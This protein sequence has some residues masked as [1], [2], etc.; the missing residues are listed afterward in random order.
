MASGAPSTAAIPYNPNG[1]TTP[2]AICT[3]IGRINT[4]NPGP[5][6]AHLLIGSYKGYSGVKGKQ[7][8]YLDTFK[9]LIRSGHAI[10]F[11]GLVPKQYSVEQPALNEGAFDAPQGFITASGHGQ[12]IVGFDD[13]IGPGGAFLIQNS[14]GPAW[15]PGPADDP[16]FNGR[17]WCSYRSWFSGQSLA[18]IMYPNNDQPP[19]GAKLVA[20]TKTAPDLY[21]KESRRY[22]QDGNSYLALIVHGT[23]AVTISQ[24]VVTGPKGLAAT[25]ALNEMMRFGY[26]YV[27]RKPAY[28]PGHNTAS[29]SVKTQAGK[30]VTYKGGFDVT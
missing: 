21:L 14:F 19:A 4:S 23:E 22:Q 2:A 20:S 27:E 3:E 12:V 18:L 28:D 25:Q 16:G 30:A 9:A 6:A 11:S 8:Q 24:I 29:L 7:S 13:S 1:A 17:I 10:A 5:D 26:A 15:N